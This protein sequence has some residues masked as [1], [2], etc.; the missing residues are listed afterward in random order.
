MAGSEFDWDGIDALR[1]LPAEERIASL[2]GMGPTRFEHGSSRAW[3]HGSPFYLNGDARRITIGHSHTPE[4]KPWAR[5]FATVAACIAF[6]AGGAALLAPGDATFRQLAGVMAVLIGGYLL[7][8]SFRVVGKLRRKLVVSGTV[9]GRWSAGDPVP[10]TAAPRRVVEP[11]KP[12]TLRLRDVPFLAAHAWAWVCELFDPIVELAEETYETL[13]D[14][15]LGLVEW[16]DYN[17]PGGVRWQRHET[18]KVRVYADTSRFEESLRELSRQAREAGL[19]VEALA[20]ERAWAAALG[21]LESKLG[22]NEPF[23]TPPFGGTDGRD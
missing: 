14:L 16:F 19:K 3:R 18:L 20:D 4:G 21:D 6:A 7:S 1:K 15:I 17:L 11:I 22:G 23:P 2:Y 12:R 5:A 10:P 8:S 13:V 9:T